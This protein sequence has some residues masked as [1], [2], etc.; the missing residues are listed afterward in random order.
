MKDIVAYPSIPSSAESEIKMTNLPPSEA[1][2]SLVKC[3]YD[4]SKCKNKICSCRK[5]NV[6]CT[7]LCRC[8]AEEEEFENQLKCQV[9]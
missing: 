4:L 8:G 6:N 5:A 1:I 2:I 9:I 7:E 3:N